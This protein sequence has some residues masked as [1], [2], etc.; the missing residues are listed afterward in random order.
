MNREPRIF[1]LPRA[2]AAIT[3]LLQILWPLVSGQNRAALTVATVIVF[4]ATSVSHAWIHRGPQWAL[5]YVATTVLFAFAVEA[6]GVAT[7]FPFTPY[8]YGTTLGPMLF[9]VPLVIPLAWAMTAYPVLLLARR[10]ATRIATISLIGAFAMASWDLFLDPQMVSQGYWSWDRAMPSLPG[11]PGIPVLNFAGW[12]GASLVLM[13]LLQWLP[14]TPAPEGVPAAVW[15]WTWIGGVIANAFFFDRIGVAV[16][17]GVA[18]GVVTVPY[19]HRLLRK[20]HLH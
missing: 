18:M 13:L 3:I 16:W 1:L 10:L 15:T 4:A 12:L 8:H 6:I 9:G 17:G 19:L 7:G 14:N 5:R 20:G 11:V 2:G